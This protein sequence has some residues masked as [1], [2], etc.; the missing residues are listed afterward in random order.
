MVAAATKTKN[1][2]KAGETL[3]ANEILVS[4]NNQYMLRMQKEDGNLCVY[5]YVNG[6]QG[7]FVWCSMKYGFK[8]P[9]LVM[10]TDGNLTF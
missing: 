2:L 9:K 3:K 8:K 6:K 7:A 5:K 4:V 1:T 10:Q